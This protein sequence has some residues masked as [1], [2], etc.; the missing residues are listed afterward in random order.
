MYWGEQAAPLSL[1]QKDGLW[2]RR[3]ASASIPVAGV[4]PESRRSLNLLCSFFYLTGGKQTEED[5]SA[6]WLRWLTSGFS[7]NKRAPHPLPELLMLNKQNSGDFSEFWLSGDLQAALLA[8]SRLVLPSSPRGSSPPRLA[9]EGETQTPC[10]RTGHGYWHPPGC[11]H[12][13]GEAVR[14]ALFLGFNA[15]LSSPPRPPLFF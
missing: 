4:K 15:S 3:A 13:V 9:S 1:E 10:P 7:S 11:R 5:Q 14:A 8:D 2:S 6:L 12:G